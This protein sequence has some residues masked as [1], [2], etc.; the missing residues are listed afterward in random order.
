MGGVGGIP[1]FSN[2]IKGKD[3]RPK[4]VLALVTFFGIEFSL[5]SYTMRSEAWNKHEIYSMRLRIKERKI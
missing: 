2:I 1:V 5:A 3:K 4:S